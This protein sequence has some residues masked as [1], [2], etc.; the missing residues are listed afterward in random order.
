MNKFNREIIYII[1]YSLVFFLS[2]SMISIFFL[3]YT[4][5]ESDLRL[6]KEINCVLENLKEGKETDLPNYFKTGYIKTKNSIFIPEKGIYLYIDKNRYYKPLYSFSALIFLLIIGFTL[7][8]SYMIY[9][10]ILELKNI[11]KDIK[12]LLE[13]L[14]LGISHKL[15]NILAA[16]AV[17]IEMLKSNCKSKYIHRLE[18]TYEILNKELKSILEFIK[19]TQFKPK[20][21]K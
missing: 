20:R 14:I 10:L 1:A 21:K 19:S 4:K 17:N 6:V 5:K 12:N 3:L 15:G 11:D 2:I 13:T 9:K 16:Q 7:L 18:Q 8:H